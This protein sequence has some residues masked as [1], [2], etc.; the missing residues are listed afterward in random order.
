MFVILEKKSM[1]VTT[2][3][4]HKGGS[5][6]AVPLNTTAFHLVPFC[7]DDEGIRPQSFG[8]ITANELLQSKVFPPVIAVSE[9]FEVNEH[10][11]KKM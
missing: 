9:E 3:Q 1:R 10:H 2:C 5:S 8:K 11:S 6:Y 4:D 7:L